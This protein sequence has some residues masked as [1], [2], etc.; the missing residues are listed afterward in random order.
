MN[1]LAATIASLYGWPI[2][3]LALGVW[4]ITRLITTDS[5]PPI[6]KLRN[7]V[8]DRFPHEGYT[9]K[10]KPN[11]ER[12]RSTNI[13]GGMYYVNEGHW[14]G[15]LLHCPWCSGWWVS[16]AVCLSYWAWPVVTLAVLIPFG[17]R[18][19]SGALHAWT[20]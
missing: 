6:E 1:N 3:I 2:I 11:P 9:A 13:S 5:F 15:E 17:L 18:V 10:H 7:W 4:S 8:F 19:V 16:L 20:D 14:I 12:A